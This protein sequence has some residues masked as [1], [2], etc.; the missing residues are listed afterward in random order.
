MTLEFRLDQANEEMIYLP[1]LRI[2][3]R[4]RTFTYIESTNA[5]ATIEFE[6]YYIAETGK[7]WES[8]MAIF[9]TLLGLLI[10]IIAIKMQVLLSKPNIGGAGQDNMRTGVISFIVMLLDFWST[11]YFWYLF[12]MIGYWWVFFKLQERVYC[13]IPTHY[14]YWTNFEQYD[15]LFGWTCGAKLAYV[16][17]KVF[18]D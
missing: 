3:Y 12:F 2:N 13:F 18:F 1:Y 6:T 8:A 14:E 16:I 9:Y 15:W 10:V 17:Y 4:E 5:Q 7:F 11:I